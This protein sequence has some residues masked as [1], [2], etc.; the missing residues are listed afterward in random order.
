MPSTSETVLVTFR[1]GFVAD[2]AT[3]CRLLDLERRGARF[4][5]KANGGFRITP[6]SVLTTD[7]IAFLQ[8]HRDEARRVLEYEADDSHLFSDS[9]P[10]PAQAS[11]F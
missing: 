1:G 11:G 9:G 8:V 2:L 6:A 7:D 5:L 4:E 10:G 3:V